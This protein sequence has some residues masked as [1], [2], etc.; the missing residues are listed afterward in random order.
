MTTW[1]CRPEEII[2]QV[3]SVDFQYVLQRWEHRLKTNHLVVNK[4]LEDKP[5]KPDWVFKFKDRIMRKFPLAELSK[6]LAL[7]K[8]TKY[9]GVLY[10][11]V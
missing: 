6:W 5:N 7:T 4:E 1:R 2:D 10:S 11:M 3:K 8:K 9:P